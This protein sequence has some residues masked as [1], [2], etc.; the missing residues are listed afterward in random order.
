M[1]PGEYGSIVGERKMHVFFVFCN[2]VENLLIFE[3]DLGD[4]AAY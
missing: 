1:P 3:I 4:H 2:H